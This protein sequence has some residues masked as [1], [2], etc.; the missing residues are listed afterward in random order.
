MNELEF[1]CQLPFPDQA[2]LA[3]SSVLFQFLLVV[4][5]FAPHRNCFFLRWSP[6]V[7]ML[8]LLAT[9]ILFL[10]WPILLYGW[11]LRSRGIDLADP[12]WSDD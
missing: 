5:I 6:Q 7:R 3:C 1:F 4:L 10:I 8:A 11:F 12:D 9:P 2:L